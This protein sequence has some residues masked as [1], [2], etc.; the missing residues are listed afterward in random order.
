MLDLFGVASDHQ[1]ALGRFR[2][3]DSPPPKETSTTRRAVRRWPR[4]SPTAIKAFSDDV[5]SF[6][7]GSNMSHLQHVCPRR[8]KGESL[9]AV[10]H[11]QHKPE[12]AI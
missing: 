9:E 2:V 5:H 10:E 4:A 11:G 8:A 7:G 6:V 12:S 3:L 1:P